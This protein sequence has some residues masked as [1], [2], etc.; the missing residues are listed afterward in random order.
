MAV[1]SVTVLGASS[2]VHEAPP[3]VVPMMLGE[4]GP[5]ANLLAARQ[6][7][8]LE[9]ET[10]VRRPTPAGRGSVDQLEPPLVVPITSGLPKMPNPT[11][12]HTELVAQEIPFSPLTSGG[13]VCAVQ[14]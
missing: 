2:T 13:M 5:E 6:F 14:A 11:A 4:F 8:G 9:H 7:E 10:A 1:K 12:V 3:F